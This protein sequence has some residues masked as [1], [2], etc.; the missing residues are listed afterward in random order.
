MLC[1]FEPV[2]LNIHQALVYLKS[3]DNFYADFSIAKGLS[4]EEMFRFS[5]IVEVQGQKNPVTE[6]IVSNGTEMSES[7]NDTET[8]YSSVEVLLSMH[9]IAFNKTTPYSEIPKITMRQVLLLHQDNGKNQFQHL[10]DKFCEE[11]DFLIFFLR[12]DLA[13]MPLKIF[14]Y[15]PWY[16]LCMV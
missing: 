2:H 10:G 1:V 16:D 3:N 12:V 8:E 14:Q 4:S 9:I 13:I 15:D 7:T 11:Q 6:K 5:D